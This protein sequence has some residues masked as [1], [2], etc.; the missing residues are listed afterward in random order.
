MITICDLIHSTTPIKIECIRFRTNSSLFLS[1]VWRTKSA[2]RSKNV[3]LQISFDCYFASV[4]R[5][6]FPR[7][8]LSVAVPHGFNIL[9]QFLQ[10]S[11]IVCCKQKISTPKSKITIHF[12]RDVFPC[13]FA[14]CMQLLGIVEAVEEYFEATCGRL[15]H[16]CYHVPFAQFTISN[17]SVFVRNR[18]IDKRS[19]QLH[20]QRWNKNKTT[21]V[22]LCWQRVK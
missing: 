21:R 12:A 22:F 9:F 13:V 1:F 8:V 6:S 14:V 19:K 18:L 17:K 4:S 10:L 11:R 7:L 16:S 20:F 2:E 5:L 15:R 3:N